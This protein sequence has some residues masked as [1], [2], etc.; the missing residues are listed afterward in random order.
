MWSSRWGGLLFSFKISSLVLSPPLL[1]GNMCIKRDWPILFS[2]ILPWQPCNAALL[3]NW[4]ATLD[5]VSFNSPNKEA[6]R[7]ER[8][9]RKCF[10]FFLRVCVWL[11]RKERQRSDFTQRAARW[12]C[13]VR[14]N[15][16]R[17]VTWRRV[18]GAIARERNGGES[19]HPGSEYIRD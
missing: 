6:A 3:H 13:I 12:G 17:T 15:K 14:V 9:R 10:F 7:E 16:K 2:L 4:I 1:P 8:G 18:K 11:R 19:L 5:T